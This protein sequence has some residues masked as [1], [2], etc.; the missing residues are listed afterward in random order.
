MAESNNSQER[1]SS[2]PWLNIPWSLRHGLHTS[3]LQ[4]LASNQRIHQDIQ[5]VIRGFS[6]LVEGSSSFG[7]VNARHFT[8][9]LREQRPMFFSSSNRIN[10]DVPPP[11][12][13]SNHQEQILN[14]DFVIEMGSERLRNNSQRA[15]NNNNNNNEDITVNNSTENREQNRNNDPADA[16][17]NNPEMRALLLMAEKYV[18]FILILLLKL[19]F[20]HRI[21]IL[22]VIGLFATFCHANSVIKREVSKQGKRQLVSLLIVILNLVTCVG[23]VYLVLAEDNLPYALILVPPYNAPITFWDVLWIV[24][25]TD[26]VLK[27]LAIL[28]KAIVVALPAK[29]LTFQKKGR[30]YLL[31][32]TT[33]QFYRT[34]APMQHWL[35][36][37][38]ESYI[39]S[40]KVFGVI[41]SAIYLVLKYKDVIRK[42]RAWK[43][44]FYGI[45]QNVT[46]GVVP[47][48]DQLKAA[49]ESCPICQ[50]VYRTPTMLQCRHIFCEEC[51]SIWFD[52]ERTCPMCRAEI[53]DDPSWRDGSTTFL[54]QI[55]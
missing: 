48:S 39:G 26:F 29:L 52:R 1:N 13:V 8:S 16:L 40:S 12:H 6:P 21:G 25:V 10:P 30:H 22:V 7:S 47:S 42:F 24:T 55:F 28:L 14:D 53:A 38:S 44:S 51:V 11:L 49:G 15:S 17:R 2:Q 3:S 31:L 18:P 36:F 4:H 43:K 20:D 5:H 41:L 32:E 9:W 37:F 33:S 34:I 46:Y 35:Y 23:F 45:L 50:D 27:L 19:I 54:I